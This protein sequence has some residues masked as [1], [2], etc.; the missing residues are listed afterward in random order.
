MPN[1]PEKIAFKASNVDI[2]NALRDTMSYTWQERIPIATQENMSEIA[3]PILTYEEVGNEFVRALMNRIALVLISSK[4]FYNPLTVFKRG[5]LQFGETVEEIF[6]NIAKAHNFDPETAE[7]EV[8]N[9]ELPDVMSAFHKINAKNFYKVTVS[10]EQLRL[11]FLSEYGLSDLIGRIIESLYNGAQYDEFLQMKHLVAEAYTKGAVYPV[12]VDSLTDANAVTFARKIKAISDNMTL[13]STLYNPMGVL[14]YSAKKDQ[15]LLITADANAYMDVDVLASAFNMS[16][17]EFM[18]RRV[19]VDNLGD[20]NII[21]ALVDRDFYMVFN[22]FEGFTENYNGQGLYWN[23]F[24]HAWRIY[25]RSPFANAIVF[26]TAEPSVTVSGTLTP[27]TVNGTQ[28]GSM[29]ITNTTT[30]TGGAST[31]VTWDLTSEAKAANFTIN[32][33]G[34]IGIPGGTAANANMPIVTLTSVYDPSKTTTLNG[35]IEG[36]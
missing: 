28:G 12:H 6:V 21:A 17:V 23:Y 22:S 14:N 30:A 29:Q 5:T 16:K 35:V 8:F 15:V 10:N 13:P 20:P 36:N 1:I 9:R 7:K 3:N 24:Y 11:A 32:S 18:G 33:Q 31:A 25:S 27:N 34:V 26:T 2:L 4:T 19:V